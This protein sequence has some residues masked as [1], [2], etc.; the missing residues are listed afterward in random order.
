M[1]FTYDVLAAAAISAAFA[2]AARAMRGVTRSG[3]IAGSV[4]S[5]VLCV[6]AGLRA[7]AVLLSVFILSYVATK[8]GRVR[9]EALGT[10]E[11]AEGRKASQII[12]NLG[13]GTVAALLSRIMGHRA[14]FLLAMTAAFAEA[15]ADTVSSEVGQAFAE[16]PRLITNWS[17][18]RAGTDGGVTL[19]GTVAGGLAALL[20]GIVSA[21]AGL[22]SWPRVG[23][24]GIVGWL[25]ML[26]D[27]LLGAT[28]ERKGI[29]DNDQVN[30]LGTLSAAILAILV[31]RVSG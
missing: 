3:A 14:I 12:A 8:L 21:G 18:V 19:T 7:F 15:A 16:E 29:L 25:G 1:S 31:S 22:I 10:A 5:F 26:F 30:F 28:L 2:G 27:S 6:S 20:I 9:K 11:R 4:A 23:L 24:V 13:V 17:R